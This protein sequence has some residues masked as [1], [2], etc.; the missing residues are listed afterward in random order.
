MDK[1]KKLRKTVNVF[2]DPEFKKGFTELA[3]NYG[4]DPSWAEKVMMKESGG[5]PSARNKKGTAT[6]LGQ[7][8]ESTARGEFGFGVDRIAKMKPLEQAELS[9]KLWNKNK[10][11]INSAGDLY[12]AN[13]YPRALGKSDDFVLG[14]TSQSQLKIGSHNSGMDF[15]KDGRITKSEVGQWFREPSRPL[16][17]AYV[18][19]VNPAQADKTFYQYPMQ[20]A[21]LAPAINPSSTPKGVFP[22]KGTGMNLEGANALEF[23]MKFVRDPAMTRSTGKM[24]EAFGIPMA[25]GG[26]KNT[27]TL[28]E[29]EI[30][31]VSPRQQAYNDSSSISQAQDGELLEKQKL[32]EDSLKLYLQGE[33]EYLKY[34][35]EIKKRINNYKP[36]GNLSN[37]VTS[38]GNLFDIKKKGS[39][40]ARP[41][42]SEETI[43]FEYNTQDYYFDEDIQP[44]N[45]SKFGDKD[46]NI[47]YD[48]GLVDTMHE[49]ALHSNKSIQDRHKEIVNNNFY[50]T[51][52]R[53]KKPTKPSIKQD[54]I[55]MQMEV[56]SITIEPSEKPMLRM[57][58]KKALLNNPKEQI[59]LTK[60]SNTKPK[61][62]SQEVVD[63]NYYPGNSEGWKDNSREAGYINYGDNTGRHSFTYDQ[64]LNDPN[65]RRLVESYGYDVPII[66]NDVTPRFRPKGS[67]G[68]VNKKYKKTIKAKAGIVNEGIMP[69]FEERNKAAQEKAKQIYAERHPDEGKLSGVNH[70]YKLEKTKESSSSSS[71]EKRD[72]VAKIKAK[73]I[74]EEKFLSSPELRAR[75]ILEQRNPSSLDGKLSGINY[76]PETYQSEKQR[77]IIAQEEWRNTPTYDKVKSVAIDASL[78]IAPELIIGKGLPIVGKVLKNTKLFKSAPEIENMVFASE[79]VPKAKPTTVINTVN[80][81]ED[82]SKEVTSS[83]IFK[84]EIDWG[85]WNKEILG[86]KSLMDEYLAIEQSFKTK[87][88]WM[89]NPD[90]SSFNGTPEQFIQMN[91]KNAKNFAGGTDES[92]QMYN[93]KLYRGSHQH[94]DDFKNRDRNDYALFTTSDRNNAI[95]Y[96]KEGEG[97][98]F[99]PGDSQWSGD[100]L[101]ELGIPQNLPIVKGS[102]SGTNWRTLNWD[103]KI[104]QG[105]TNVGHTNT[106]NRA[107]AHL[108]E[109]KYYAS[110]PNPQQYGL[111]TNYDPS[112][113]YLSTDVYANYVKNLNNKEAIA[114]IDD[115]VDTMGDRHLLPTTVH[116][117]DTDRVPVKSLFY[118]NGMF[119]MTNPNIYKGAIPLGI[120]LGLGKKYKK[121]KK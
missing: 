20:K 2:R 112:K 54:K 14:D 53:Y 110:Q 82:I 90:G 48:S 63:F 102:G 119:D 101:Y 93:D 61:E 19:K 120:G 71:F 44:I 4:I 15:N 74:M 51:V 35:N 81:I 73:Q 5:D 21:T 104:A 43:P 25:E 96:G 33:K 77:Q 92:A 7:I 116:A 38:V 79:Y 31:S 111:P 11:K 76:T 36:L 69:S 91:S 34:S 118:N 86:N 59:R 88:K 64:V 70:S 8:I 62:S 60:F 1:K 106:V 98:I 115:V 18:P 58:S 68:L 95:A 28:P 52:G 113:K 50:G 3:M 46:F 16:D 103:E 22:F 47:R 80:K 66:D 13:F 83:P 78:A 107:Q 37:V 6:G 30:K 17:P 41:I 105:T 100:G 27:K 89:K 32:Y 65:T 24:A 84:S 109:L 121:T 75:Q 67:Q 39:G 85:A 40:N 10:D 23:M 9:F 57:E 97:R 12:L 108:D 87:G 45:I 114:R 56:P 55:S 26:I 72:K 117:I 94:I 29:T 49:H 42:Y 99:R